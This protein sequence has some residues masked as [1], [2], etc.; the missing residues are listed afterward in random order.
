MAY[1]LPQGEPP[2]HDRLAFLEEMLE[3]IARNAELQPILD[4]LVLKTASLLDADEGSIRLAGPESSDAVTAPRPGPDIRQAQRTYTVAKKTRGRVSESW[5][6]DVGSNVLLFL[7]GED[8][9]V[10]PDLAHDDRF[11]GLQ[12]ARSHV[13]ALLA[14][15]LMV[16][17]RVTGVL[18]V[19]MR[20][21]GRVWSPGEVRLMSL[22]AGTTARAIETA[23]LHEDKRRLEKQEE[24]LK[25]ERRDLEHARRIQHRF[26]PAR[27]LPF[28][29]WVVCGRVVSA[30]HVGGDA[31]DY[32]AIDPTRLAVSVADV[33][34]KG[35]PAALIM[36]CFQA[37]FRSSRRSGHRPAMS[38]GLVEESLVPMLDDRQFITA[39]AAE[40]DVERGTLRYANA[41]HN[42]PLL[43]RASGEILELSHGDTPLTVE[44]DRPFSDHELP[45]APGDALLLYSDGVTEA[46]NFDD[47]M[48]GEERLRATWARAGAWTPDRAM[49]AIFAE[50]ESFRGL[51][52]QSDDIT[53][54]VV[55]PAG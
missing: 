44:P 13:R 8:H 27:P 34:G 24:E 55:G 25:R 26:L 50:V 31:F 46:I 40:L 43:R 33:S 51:A 45:F 3:V 2:D 29:G 52:Q 15:R 14:V 1:D 16:D 5:P 30:R 54:V 18:A 32:F 21:P 47:E 28:G 23:R 42:P 37:M 17:G 36:S 9:L 48:Y 6:K 4:W 11:R 35:T 7:G 49:A 41:G 19:S 12:D 53:I 39:F 22:V 20:E 38:L 10:T